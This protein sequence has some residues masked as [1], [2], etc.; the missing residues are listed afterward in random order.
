MIPT[1]SIQEAT[2]YLG[3][4]D[5][6]STVKYCEKHDI[7]IFSTNGRK[8]YLI[9]SQFEYTRAKQLIQYLKIKYKDRWMEAFKAF[10]S[11]NILNVLQIEETGKQIKINSKISVEQQ[12]E[13]KIPITT[14][15]NK[16]FGPH[17]TKF[18]NDVHNGDLHNL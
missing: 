17:A 5:H 3:F 4:K 15:Q 8:K 18:L 10:S 1:I 12:Q 11:E 9:R 6:R 13:Q 14:I 7:N 16:T 2:E